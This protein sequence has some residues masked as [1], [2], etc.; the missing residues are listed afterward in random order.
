MCLY[1]FSSPKTGN[2]KLPKGTAAYQ[3][4][5][6]QSRY[7]VRTC[8]APCGRSGKVRYKRVPGHPY[9]LSEKLS[10]QRGSSLRHVPML[11]GLWGWFWAVLWTLDK[12]LELNGR[13]IATNLYLYVVVWSSSSSSA[14]LRAVHRCSHPVGCN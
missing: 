10:T 3:I 4:S 5:D 9:G 12:E 2:S 6:S 7:Q 8:N 14:H 11:A 1:R 13:N